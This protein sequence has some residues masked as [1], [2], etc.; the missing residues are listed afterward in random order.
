MTNPAIVSDI[1]GTTRDKIE[2]TMEI[3]GV[4]Y[5]FIGTAG[6]R[7]KPP[8]LLKISESEPFCTAIPKH[9]LGTAR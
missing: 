9:S 7:V 6:I 1:P 5:R 2:D 4:L 8:M 3:D